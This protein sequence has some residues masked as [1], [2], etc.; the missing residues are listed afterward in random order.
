MR[1]WLL[2]SELLCLRH[3]LGAFCLC[4][5]TWNLLPSASPL[6]W[7]LSFCSQTHYLYSREVTTAATDKEAPPLPCTPLLFCTPSLKL[8]SGYLLTSSPSP[9]AYLQSPIASAPSCCLKVF[10]QRW[11]LPTVPI[12]HLKVAWASASV[13]DTAAILMLLEAMDSFYSG[14]FV[15]GRWLP[16]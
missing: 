13:T 5:S 10:P 8:L 9:V 12:S 4:S 11:Q 2:F 1:C 6:N 7:F 3:P 16:L 14:G 15:V